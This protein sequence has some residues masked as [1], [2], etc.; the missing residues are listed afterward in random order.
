[1]TATTITA[2][3]QV[4]AQ[5]ST[6]GKGLDFMRADQAGRQVIIDEASLAIM[7]D[8]LP[9]TDLKNLLNGLITEDI[10]F[11]D[12]L[13]QVPNTFNEDSANGMFET[14]GDEFDFVKEYATKHPHRVWTL[15][16]ED[17]VYQI[18]QGIQYVNRIGYYLVEED[19]E[20]AD[21]IFE[22]SENAD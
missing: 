2:L 13:T 8:P 6:L 5:I 19:I 1:M 10:Y 17:G 15:T 16:E 14:Y 9:S 11:F 22:D 3:Q 12:W 18:S 20:T 4:L 21:L 7:G